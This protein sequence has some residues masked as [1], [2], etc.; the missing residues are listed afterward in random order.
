[1]ILTRALGRIVK[2]IQYN[3]S[4]CRPRLQQ[5]VCMNCYYVFLE[6]CGT[7]NIGGHFVNE[8][9]TGYCEC[10]GPDAAQCVSLCPP[11]YVRCPPHSK[12]VRTKVPAL[13]GSFCTCPS[14][15]CVQCKFRFSHFLF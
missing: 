5:T 15:K 2:A 3:H 14:W 9:C 8:W 13:P 1:M 12:T 7:H 11:V 10:T 6:P 4:D